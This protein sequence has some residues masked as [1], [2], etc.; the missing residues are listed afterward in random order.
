MKLNMKNSV[1]FTVNGEN[2]VLKSS[3]PFINTNATEIEVEE[4]NGKKYKIKMNN[5]NVTLFSLDGIELG[6][7]FVSLSNSGG[8]R[9]RTR[10][11]RRRKHRTRRRRRTHTYIAR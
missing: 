6:P 11:N 5:D 9:K 8:T 2:I 10:R 3:K 4:N 1:N 7:I